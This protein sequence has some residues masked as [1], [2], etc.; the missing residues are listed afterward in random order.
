MIIDKKEIWKPIPGYEGLYEV[1]D[2]GNVKSLERLVKNNGGFN[3]VKEK[4]LKPFKVGNPKKYYYAVDLCK[5]TKKVHQ[6]VA[7]AFLN[8]IPKGN[9][10]VVDHINNNKLDNRLENLQIISNR[11]NTSKDW[12]GNSSQFT[13]V[14]WSKR[15]QKWEA[16]ITIANRKK[17]LGCFLDETDAFMA[18][19]KALVELN[20]TTNK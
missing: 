6:L 9:T 12:K 2:F 11:E 10:I 19:Q 17:S 15:D 20:N 14:S 18:Y 7:L 5:K 8:H 13:G 4:I 1:S 3:M 16:Y